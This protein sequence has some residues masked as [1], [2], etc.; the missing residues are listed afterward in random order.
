MLTTKKTMIAL[1]LISHLILAILISAC[2][3]KQ[4][5]ASV[6][7]TPVSFSNDIAPIFNN[8]CTK[9][10]SGSQA[11][12]QLDL[13]NY[14]SIMAGGKT[15]AVINPGDASKS[16]LISLVQSGKMPKKGAK[17]TADQVKALED[18]VSSGAQDN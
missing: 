10:H 13:S 5:S 4:P 6:T 15:G 14:A 11:S 3:S 16:L 18:W 17:L 9:C 12:G 8:R 2:G 1:G 7:T